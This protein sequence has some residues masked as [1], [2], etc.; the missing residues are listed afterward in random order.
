M[1]RWRGE[2][3]EGSHKNS[4]ARRRRIFKMRNNKKIRK[5]TGSKRDPLERM[6]KKRSHFEIFHNFENS[7]KEEFKD[8]KGHS[9]PAFYRLRATTWPE[10]DNGVGGCGPEFS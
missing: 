6:K 8:I 1:E 10:N 9:P 2:V 3:G 5:R 7:Q 4:D